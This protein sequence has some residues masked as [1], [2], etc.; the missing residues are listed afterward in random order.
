LPPV[1]K[2]E[3]I[4]YDSRWPLL[5]RVEAERLI[6]I[7]DGELMRLHH[8]GSTSVPGLAAKP[9]ID[10][11]AEVRDIE[12]LDGLNERMMAA[13]YTPKGEYGITG[14]RYFFKGSA[15]R[16]THHLHAFQEGN[17]EIVRHLLFRDFL[18]SHPAEAQAYGD[19]KLSLASRFTADI[20]SYMD[21]KDAFIKDIDRQAAL[22]AAGEN[23]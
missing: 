22:R 9:L 15:E 12:K 20:E 6:K 4:A 16:H 1:R 10:M 7:L 18:R 21:G 8:I 5:Y 17:A 11:L 23:P 2:V 14:R 13:G 3:V 19:L